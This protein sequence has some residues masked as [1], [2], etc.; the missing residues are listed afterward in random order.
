MVKRAHDI[1]ATGDKPILRTGG[2]RHGVVVAK[3]VR[4]DLLSGR[5]LVALNAACRQSPRA[6]ECLGHGALP[7]APV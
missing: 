4:R 5:V 6:Q 2:F 1:A 3:E 7:S